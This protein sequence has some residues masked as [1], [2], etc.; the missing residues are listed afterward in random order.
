LRRLL[1]MAVLPI[2]DAPLA[3]RLAFTLVLFA[4][5]FLGGHGT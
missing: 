4:L 1:G 3:R 5:V 2:V